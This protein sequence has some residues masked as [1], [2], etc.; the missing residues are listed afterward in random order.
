MSGEEAAG[1]G[2]D[3]VITKRSPFSVSDTVTRLCSQIAARGMRVFAVIDHGGEAHR[4]G[5]ELRET[6][7]VIFGSPVAGTPVMAAAALA[8]LDLPLRVLIWADGPTTK[9]SYTATQTLAARYDLTAELAGRLAGIDAL[10][11]A[12][13]DGPAAP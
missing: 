6:Q 8:A 7:V 5:L 13:V 9:L 1:N 4:A 10:T 3:G 12:V 2:V 11:D